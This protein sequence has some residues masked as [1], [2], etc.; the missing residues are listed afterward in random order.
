M[1]L[2][3]P[4]DCSELFN[5]GQRNSGVYAIKPNQSQPFNVYCEMSSGKPIACVLQ[6]NPFPNET[7]LTDNI[8]GNQ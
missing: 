6:S 1:F 7:V 5:R 3:L 8:A 2:E 4:A